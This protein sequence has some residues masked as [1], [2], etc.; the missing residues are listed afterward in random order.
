MNNKFKI[1]LFITSKIILLNKKDSFTE[2]LLFPTFKN[3]LV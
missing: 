2:N 1:F 3:Y